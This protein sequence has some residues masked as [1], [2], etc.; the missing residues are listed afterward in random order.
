[1]QYK[2]FQFVAPGKDFGIKYDPNMIVWKNLIMI[3]YSDSGMCLAAVAANKLDLCTAMAWDKQ[4][5]KEYLLVG[6]RS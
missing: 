6:K 2:L 1:V 4:T 5:R 3:G